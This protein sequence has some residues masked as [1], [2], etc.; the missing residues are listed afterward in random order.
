[1]CVLVN[2]TNIGK[3]VWMLPPLHADG[4]AIRAVKG[5]TTYRL[6]GVPHVAIAH[7]GVH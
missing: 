2:E 7:H 1:M 3:P 5:E 6:G 4:K